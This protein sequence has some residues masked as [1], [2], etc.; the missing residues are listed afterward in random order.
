MAQQVAQIHDRYM[1][2]MMMI[3]WKVALFGAIAFYCYNRP[4]HLSRSLGSHET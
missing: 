3:V 4:A 1:M 2:M